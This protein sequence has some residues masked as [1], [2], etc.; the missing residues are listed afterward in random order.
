MGPSPS[1]LHILLPGV[2]VGSKP[3]ISLPSKIKGVGIALRGSGVY[4]SKSVELCVKNEDQTNRVWTTILT[5]KSDVL[6]FET[7]C[8]YQ[9]HDCLDLLGLVISNWNCRTI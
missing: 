1:N 8:L 6:E 2:V 3:V 4:S 7:D 9:K 5:L